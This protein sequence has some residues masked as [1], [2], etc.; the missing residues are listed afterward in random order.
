MAK[1]GNILMNTYGIANVVMMQRRRYY[2]KFPMNFPLITNVLTTQRRRCC[3]FDIPGLTSESEDYPGSFGISENN[4]VG[5][6]PFIP[7]Y[8]ISAFR[9]EKAQHLRRCPP[10]YT[11]NPG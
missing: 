3:T 10:H 9:A 11:Y 8:F 6:V 2:S 5:V 1:C 7:R 4:A